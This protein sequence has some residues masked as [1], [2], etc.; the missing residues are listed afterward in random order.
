MEQKQPM[1]VYEFLVPQVIQVVSTVTGIEAE[2][3]QQNNL[4]VHSFTVVRSFRV[5]FVCD[6]GGGC[7]TKKATLRFSQ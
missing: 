5:V 2:L 7:K 3:Q 6:V 4:F 1:Y